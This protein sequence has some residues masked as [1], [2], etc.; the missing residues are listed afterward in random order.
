MQIYVKQRK[1]NLVHCIF[2]NCYGGWFLSALYGFINIMK[3]Y[4]NKK[5][6]FLD[7]DNE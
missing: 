7:S 6:G 5:N 1:Q 2:Y 3:L 4:K